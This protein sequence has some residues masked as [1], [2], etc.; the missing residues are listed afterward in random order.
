MMKRFSRALV[1]VLGLF[2]LEYFP[3]PPKEPRALIRAKK[4]AEK[5]GSISHPAQ[6]GNTSECRVPA[7]EWFAIIEGETGDPVVILPQSPARPD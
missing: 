6:T 4:G 5:F 3:A 2:G 7:D 1:G